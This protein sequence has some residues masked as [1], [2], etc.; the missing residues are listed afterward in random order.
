MKKPAICAEN[1]NGTFRTFS[2]ITFDILNPTIEMINITDIAIGLTHNSHFNGHSPR[3][4]SIAQHCVMVHDE[5]QKAKPD[6][7]VNMKLMALLHDASEAYTGDIIK[8]LKV[9]VPDFEA[10]EERIMEVVGEKFNLPIH[11]KEK[12]KKYDLKVQNIEYEG[13][14]NGEQIEYWTCKDAFQEFLSRYK[15]LTNS[16]KKN[17]YDTIN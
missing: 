15:T 12:I 6:A 1:L 11:L 8:P 17:N 4:F 3:F 10:I 16:L 13:F 5:Y 9:L 14:Y 7:D 2:G